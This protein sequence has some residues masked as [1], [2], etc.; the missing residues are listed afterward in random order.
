LLSISYINTPSQYPYLWGIL[1]HDIIVAEIGNDTW[2]IEHRINQNPW[3]RNKTIRAKNKY[4]G[5][6]RIIGV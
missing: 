2:G 6:N 3:G 1:L 4:M 5:Y